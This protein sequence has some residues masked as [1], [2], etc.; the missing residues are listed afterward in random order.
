MNA[1]FRSPDADPTVPAASAVVNTDSYEKL[2]RHDVDA[3]L[4]ARL[5]GDSTDVSALT[6]YYSHNLR[7]YRDEELGSSP[8][9]LSLV[10]DH[11]TSWMG[12]Q[13]QQIYTGGPQRLSFGAG[14]EI[15]QI[16]GSHTLGR[17]R[18]V[19]GHVRAVEEIS[20]PGPV[21]IGLFGRY[22]RYLNDDHLGAGADARFQVTDDLA[23]LA[24]YSASAR[25]PTYSELY[26][27][28][29][30]VG[31]PGEV[32]A[33]R[34]TMAEAGV[35]FRPAPGAAITLSYGARSVRDPVLLSASGT[36]NSGTLAGHGA[37]YPGFQI[38]N[39]PDLLT[40]SLEAG[41]R[42]RFWYVLLE[43]TFLWT[44]QESDGGGEPDLYPE[45]AARGG[46]YFRTS[47]FNGSLDLKTGFRG[48]YQAESRGAYFD[49]VA[50]AYADHPGAAAPGGSSV[51]FL[52]TAGIGDAVIY[53]TW[54]NLADQLWYR[55]PYYP[56]RDRGIRFGL[57]W[58]FLD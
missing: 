42:A 2:T 54:E 47:L 58:E 27:T 25:V 28:D 8:N 6:L 24:G 30:D 39:G 5:I 48:T 11:R 38:T 34:H 51:D 52:L 20:L 32:T 49:Q 50:L 17:R 33:E 9:G 7:E 10:Q 23:V 56:I 22:D 15:R 55:T 45:I 21:R 44:V 29:P 14:V 3:T 37:L 26:W 53:F 4:A 19:I 41:V 36:I 31:R 43:G 1:G 18:N 35:E 12:A 16:E 13:I 46:V 40:H 57:S